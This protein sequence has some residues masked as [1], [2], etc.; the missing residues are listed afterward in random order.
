MCYKETHKSF[1]PKQIGSNSVNQALYERFLALLQPSVQIT[2]RSGPAVLTGSMCSSSTGRSKM[3]TTPPQTHH[4]IHSSST[5]HTTPRTLVRALHHSTLV[6]AHPTTSKLPSQ[7]FLFPAEGRDALNAEDP[8][9]TA[10]AYMQLL[11]WL[12]SSSADARVQLATAHLDGR[13]KHTQH[14]MS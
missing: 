6:I 3:R 10:S 9:Q 8:T 2:P 4:S 7:T 12:D 11:L 13:I 1:A 5:S 14:V